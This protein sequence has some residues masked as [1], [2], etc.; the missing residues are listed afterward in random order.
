MLCVVRSN[1]RCR[2]AH[3]WPVQDE[4]QEGMRMAPYVVGVAGQELL[5]RQEVRLQLLAHQR[6][7]LLLLEVHCAPRQA[8]TQ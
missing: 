6:V 1:K 2:P 7:A 8:T 5:V 4:L 3:L